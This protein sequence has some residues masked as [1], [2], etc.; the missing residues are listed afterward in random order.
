MKRFLGIVA[1]AAVF[2]SCDNTANSDQKIKDSLDS[3]TKLQKESIDKS[4]EEAKENLDS[5]NNA[6]KEVVDSVV[7]KIKDTS[8]QR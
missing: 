6:K 4:S 8:T 3:I 1:I 2:V 5:I 7:D